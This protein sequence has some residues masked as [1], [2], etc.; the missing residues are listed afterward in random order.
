[1]AD[2]FADLRLRSRCLGP[3]RGA[4]QAW[5]QGR[6]PYLI[7][8][9]RLRSPELRQRLRAV[10][11]ALGPALVPSESPHITLWACGFPAQQ[12]WRSDDLGPAALVEQRARLGPWLGAPVAVEVGGAGAFA[13]CAFLEVVDPGGQLQAARAALAAQGSDFRAG[14]YVP[15]VTAGLFRASLPSAPLLDALAP[16][17]GLPSLALAARIELCA[18]DPRRYRGAL[19]P[20]PPG[21]P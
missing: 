3:S 21:A 2:P 12:P 18:I 5:H 10:Q 6:S 17:A 20:W 15:H 16:L 19:R 11:Q 4:R 14:P 7:W 13:S 1:M 8:G 9:L